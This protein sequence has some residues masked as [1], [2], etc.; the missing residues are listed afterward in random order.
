MFVPVEAVASHGG[1]VAGVGV[2]DGQ[3]QSDHAVTTCRIRE[4]LGIIAGSGERLLVPRIT[5]ACCFCEF[6]EI[7]GI[8]CQVQGHH[9]VATVRVSERVRIVAGSGNILMFVPVEAVA[10]HGGGVASIGVV[11]GEV[12]GVHLHTTVGILMTEGVLAGGGVLGAIPDEATAGTLGNSGV[13]GGVDIQ[14]EGNDTVAAVDR[15]QSVGVFTCC[16]KIL[17]IE[18]VAVTITNSCIDGCVISRK[19]G[20][21]NRLGEL[22]TC[23]SGY[24]H[25]ITA[26]TNSNLCSRSP[27]APTIRALHIR[28]GSQGCSSPRTHAIRPTNVYV[29]RND[30][31][32]IGG[33]IYRSSPGTYTILTANGLHFHLVFGCR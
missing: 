14:R 27:C 12:Q 21:S 28:A 33:E 31:V 10:G 30:T 2:V 6:C 5:V 1:G 20:D 29:C 23:S 18:I 7:S 9:R 8:N 22:I 19:A 24:R 16:G 11:D 32:V 15:L 26:S 17:S 25:C 13:C 3:M 4:G